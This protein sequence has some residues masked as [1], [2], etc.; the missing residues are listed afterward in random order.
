MD[1]SPIA[2]IS[3]LSDDLRR[4]LYA[5]IRHAGRPVTRD[6]AAEEAGISRK[7]AAF[8]LDKLVAAGL[9]RAGY[10]R[11]SGIRRV[12]RSP[13]VYEAADIEVQVTIPPRDPGLLA[14]VLVDAVLA[15]GARQTALRVAEERGRRLG[16]A[17]RERIRP[18]RLGAERALTHAHAVL[19][20]L[21]FEPA[22]VAP[23]RLR[24]RNCPFRPLAAESPEL[25]CALNRAFL[26]GVLTGLGA[27]TVEAVPLPAPD[28]C[29]VELD[30]RP[31]AERAG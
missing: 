24:L 3:V 17:E 31:A 9:L 28:A 1:G 21:G 19:E 29:C 10:A 22:R 5:F 25:V 7:L 16:E 12:G 23:T 6:E 26:A 2:A 18:G 14:A 8:H 20:R 4:R 15:A 11:A 30:G 13:K 27:S